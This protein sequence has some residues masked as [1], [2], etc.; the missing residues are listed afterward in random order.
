MSPAS[1]IDL[2]G[3]L[4]WRRLKLGKGQRSEKDNTNKLFDNY[5][6][7]LRGHANIELVCKNVDSA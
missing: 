1:Y 5:T 4:Y 3:V 7:S 6:I 2:N